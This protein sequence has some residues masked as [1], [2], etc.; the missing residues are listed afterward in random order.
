MS[1]ITTEPAS[2]LPACLA[3]DN[4]TSPYFPSM[5]AAGLH[6]VIAL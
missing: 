6:T 2:D 5:S 4:L 1:A 3:R